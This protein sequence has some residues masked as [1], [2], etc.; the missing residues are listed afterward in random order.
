LVAV[1]ACVSLAVAAISPNAAAQIPIVA[2]VQEAAF[3]LRENRTYDFGS[4]VVRCRPGQHL[5]EFGDC[6]S[7][8]AGPSTGLPNFWRDNQFGTKQLDCIR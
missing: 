4:Q 5:E 1:L 2:R 3:T 8:L 6:A 7:A